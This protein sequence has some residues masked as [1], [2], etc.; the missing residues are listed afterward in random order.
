MKTLE[1][2]GSGKLLDRVLNSWPFCLDTDRITAM[3]AL[4]LGPTFSWIA[5]GS[6]KTMSLYYNG[7]IYVRLMLPF[8]VGIQLRWAGSNPQVREYLQLGFGW[9]LNGR[10]GIHARI[11]SD[12]SS[13]AGVSGPNVGQAWGW[14]DGTK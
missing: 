11:Q 3:V 6:D 8:W 9:K 7:I 14:A 2:V 5:W 1:N 12:A 10:F 13:S 4:A